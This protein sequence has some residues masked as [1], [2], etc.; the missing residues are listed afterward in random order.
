VALKQWRLQPQL[1]A[2]LWQQGRRLP[3]CGAGDAVGAVGDD[4]VAPD[5]VGDDAGDVLDAG[6][7]QDV[8][9]EG[10]TTAHDHTTDQEVAGAGPTTMVA[11]IVLGG[12][13]SILQ[14][15]PSSGFEVP[16]ATNRVAVSTEDQF[17]QRC[18]SFYNF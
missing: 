15:F 8:L 1:P 6:D 2:R 9:G 14:A 16:T 13:K 11:A 17:Q 7:D 3:C 18:W 12:A 10:H 5:A 4:G